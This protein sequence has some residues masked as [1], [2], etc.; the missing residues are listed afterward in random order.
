MRNKFVQELRK[1]R[2][3]LRG[4]Y[5][6]VAELAET[7]TVNVCRVL[8]NQPHSY[9][10]KQKVLKAAKEIYRKKQAEKEKE[11]KQLEKIIA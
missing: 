7:N 11:Q 5:P 6:A 10:M 8:N 1:L 4:S 3:E 9:L 2:V